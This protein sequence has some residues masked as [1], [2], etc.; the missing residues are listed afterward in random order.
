MAGV[1]QML[2]AAGGAFVFNDVIAVNRL[3]YNL[4]AA[5]VAA[6]W[7]QIAPLN[8]TV[9]VNSGVVVGS[10]S[11]A[12]PGFDTGQTFPAGSILALVNAG[13]I[14]GRGGNGA[15]I[16]GAGSRNA[17]YPEMPGDPG[18]LALRAQFAISISNSGTIGGGGGGGGGGGANNPAVSSGTAGGG[19]GGAGSDPGYMNEGGPFG[20][21]GPGVSQGTLTT[22]SIGSSSGDGGDGGKG[23]NLGQAGAQG[24]SGNWHAGGSGGAPGAA[25]S[26]NSI[27]NWVATGTRLGAIT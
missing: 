12:T 15:R 10:A 8:A 11:T 18:G 21:G 5:A 26:G 23:G 14:V 9:T 3:N 27:I 1:H 2:L 19:G 20:G 25:V 6:G 4:R 22:G 13:Y 7:N 16:T 17:S 24:S